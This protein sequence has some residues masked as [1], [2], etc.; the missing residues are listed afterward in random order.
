MCPNRPLKISMDNRYYMSWEL[1]RDR[2][3]RPPINRR[4]LLRLG[5]VLLAFLLLLVLASLIVLGHEAR[6]G[7]GNSGLHQAALPVHAAYAFMLPDFIPGAGFP[8]MPDLFGGIRDFVLGCG[9]AYRLL[10]LAGFTVIAVQAYRVG[11]KH[12]RESAEL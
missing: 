9:I 8:G 1:G 7:G 12:G 4:A 5:L 3:P 10:L 2:R 6:T 11:R